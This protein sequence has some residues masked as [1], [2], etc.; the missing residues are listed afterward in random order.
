MSKK[1]NKLKKKKST[2]VS[3]SK[4]VIIEIDSAFTATEYIQS[5]GFLLT[6]FGVQHLTENFTEKKFSD[7]YAITQITNAGRLVQNLTEGLLICLLQIAET[8]GEKR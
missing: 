4:K 6:L 5:I 2:K 8:G 3:Q 1:N 7:E